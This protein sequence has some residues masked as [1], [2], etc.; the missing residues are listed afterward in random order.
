MDGQTARS[1]ERC[2]EWCAFLET[3]RQNP[4]YLPTL[5]GAVSSEDLKFGADSTALPPAVLLVA[6]AHFGLNLRTAGGKSP[7]VVHSCGRDFSAR[8]PN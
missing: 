8:I 6:A 2:R 7:I 1:D 3:L 4:G 5:H